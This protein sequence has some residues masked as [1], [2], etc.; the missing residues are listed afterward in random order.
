MRSVRTKKDK[1]I[2]NTITE[3]P[4][5]IPT[6]LSAS[7]SLQILYNLKR[8]KRLSKTHSLICQVP[9]DDYELFNKL[10]NNENHKH[11]S[12]ELKVIIA[13]WKK[14][15]NDFPPSEKRR[16]DNADRFTGVI[17]NH[18]KLHDRIK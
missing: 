8:N 17:L 9:R 15:T 13:T 10:F 2:S 11:I 3:M 18:T 7:S 4:R 12:E 1:I 16:K 6:D 14:E 5:G